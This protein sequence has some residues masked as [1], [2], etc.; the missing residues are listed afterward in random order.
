MKW[1]YTAPS[2]DNVTVSMDKY[3]MTY[4]DYVTITATGTGSIKLGTSSGASDITTLSSSGTYKWY[5]PVGTYTVYATSTGNSTVNGKTASTSSNLTVGKADG[6][7]SLTINPNVIN[8]GS[9]TSLSATG[10]GTI[11]IGDGGVSGLATG[12]GSASVTYTPT[13]GGEHTIYAKSTGDSNHYSETTSKSL[14]VY[15]STV[16]S[17]AS[18]SVSYGGKF[19][20]TLKDSNGNA[21]PSGLSVKIYGVRSDG[22]YEN[23]YNVTTDG[24]GVA[25]T[26]SLNFDWGNGYSI[27]WTVTFNGSGYYYGTGSKTYANVPYYQS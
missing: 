22:A 20:V 9:S 4:G 18:S 10:L 8:L 15:T 16:Q 25:S 21:L 3:S 27:S 2:D 12:T 7:I 5:A 13:K 26:P 6:E 1:T 14:G 24:N 11:S 23:T 19:S 17:N